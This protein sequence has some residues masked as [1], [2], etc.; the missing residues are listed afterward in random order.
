MTD[1]RDLSWAQ[2]VIDWSDFS[3]FRKKYLFSLN[4]IQ[5][6]SNDVLPSLLQCKHWVHTWTPDT[7]H[8]VTKST[9]FSSHQGAARFKQL[10]ILTHPL[11]TRLPRHVFHLGTFVSIDISFLT[12]PW[13]VLQLF[14]ADCGSL[15]G[16]VSLNL[17]NFHLWHPISL[18]SASQSQIS[19]IG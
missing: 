19:R 13:R 9:L 15:R 3:T 18:H 17:Y 4:Y 12:T 1:C 8:A 16:V 10:L 5:G 7:R 14:W 2:C 6:N 11:P